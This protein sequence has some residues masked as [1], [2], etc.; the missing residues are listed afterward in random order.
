MLHNHSDYSLP[1][2]RW[3]NIRTEGTRILADAVF[4]ENDPQAK[5]VS[6]KVERDFVRAVSVGAWRPDENDV[7]QEYDSVT[8][9]RTI[10]VNKWVPR[11]ASIVTIPANHNALAFYDRETSKLMDNSEVLKLFDIPQNEKLKVENNMFEKIAKILN[12]ADNS[13]EDD[14]SAAVQIALSDNDRL[15]AENLTL[16]S[17]I[18]EMNQAAQALKKEEA[19]AL[20]D[21]AIKDGRIDAK[22]KENYLKLFD[23]D[24]DS[25]KATIEAI[26]ARKSVA[27]QIAASGNQDNAELADLQKKSWDELDKSGKLVTL[28][29]KYPDLYKEK[30][31]AR[32]GVEPK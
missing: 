24:H 28:K 23:L 6:D 5:I 11:E 17:R 16:T 1:I 30:F 4:D 26:P 25:A 3:D 20:V 21:A 14:V 15:K 32:Y 18:D 13:S 7:I 31:K 27:A 2:G 19:V 12:L 10:T 9:K 22:V 8:G 29:D